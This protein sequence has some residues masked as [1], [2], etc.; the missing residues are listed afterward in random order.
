ML[1]DK[2]LNCYAEEIATMIRGKVKKNCNGCL[3]DHPSQRQ[4]DCLIMEHGECKM[5]Y[6]N[7][8]VENVFKE[9]VIKDYMKS[10]DFAKRTLLWIV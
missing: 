7:H 3:I 1:Q 5:L 8:A 2:L 10:I 6:F 4:H 9:I